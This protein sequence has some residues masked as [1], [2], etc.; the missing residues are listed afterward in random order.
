MPYL[1]EIRIVGFDFAPL[2]WA[3]CDGSVLPIAEFQ[4]LFELLGTTYGGDGLSSFGLPDLRGRRVV[5]PGNGHERGEL[6]GQEQ[7]TLTE[8]QL[9]QHTHLG[10][11]S[12]QPG[13]TGSPKGTYWA[14]APAR[15]RP[16]ASTPGQVAMHG[17]AVQPTG[18]GL[19]HENMPPFQV[20]NFII[21]LSGDI[22]VQ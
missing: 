15:T 17:A 21:S 6:A 2:D 11:G 18:G 13:T 8:A 7:V 19:P 1:G 14:T 4:S 16:Y 10:L 9:P 12:S 3:L 5:H 22:P 20:V